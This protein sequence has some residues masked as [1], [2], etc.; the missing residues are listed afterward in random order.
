MP[1]A[2]HTHTTGC[3]VASSRRQLVGGSIL[4]ALSGAAIAGAIVLPDP[5]EASAPAHCRSYPQPLLKKAAY[6]SCAVKLT[7]DR[8]IKPL[9]IAVCQRCAT[10]TEQI[11]EQAITGLRKPWRDLHLRL[12]SVTDPAGEQA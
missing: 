7:R 1:K 9:L 11:R 6:S 8:P 5:G 12:I 2:T 3:V 10:T 4:A